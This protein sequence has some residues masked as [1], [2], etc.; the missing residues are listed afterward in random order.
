MPETRKL[1]KEPSNTKAENKML[2]K[3]LDILEAV[4]LVPAA[5]P[6][7]T[8]P[9]KV[10]AEVLE[11]LNV[12]VTSSRIRKLKPI[13]ETN[14]LVQQAKKNRA[15]G[16][17]QG[18]QEKKGPDEGSGKKHRSHQEEFGLLTEKGAKFQKSR[19]E[20]KNSPYS[21]VSYEVRQQL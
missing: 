21:R 2:K 16:A 18:L 14:R 20:K 17:N 11:K 1:Q 7:P 15:Q 6:P 8:T 3:K 10:A 5:T 13:T 4:E 12:E 19:E 9:D